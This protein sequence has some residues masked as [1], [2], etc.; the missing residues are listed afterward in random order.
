VL[1]TTLVLEG[2]S[3]RLDPS[4]SP[5]AQVEALLAPEKNTA[6]GRMVTKWD[7]ARESLDPRCDV[8]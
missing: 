5:I 3:S 6:F 2:W 4:H 7:E 1:V 8:W